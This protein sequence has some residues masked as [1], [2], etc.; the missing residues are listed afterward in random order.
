VRKGEN[1][2][3]LGRKTSILDTA[4]TTEKFP[5]E[6]VSIGQEFFNLPSD[7]LHNS[8]RLTL[9]TID[10]CR[11]AVQNRKKLPYFLIDN[12]HLL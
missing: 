10:S 11:I 5:T 3:Q 1:R 12:A 2:D 4:V 7:L 9:C 8:E 6:H